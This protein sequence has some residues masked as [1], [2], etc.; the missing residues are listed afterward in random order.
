MTSKMLSPFIHGWKVSNDG[1]AG[2]FLPDYRDDASLSAPVA[3]YTWLHLNALD[4][5]CEAWLVADPDIDAVATKILTAQDSRPRLIAH[6]DQ[7]LINLRGVNLNEG[8]DPTD[9]VGIRFIISA[10]RIVSV[11]RRPLKATTDMVDLLNNQNAPH[12]PGQ[13]IAQFALRL[14]ERMGPFISE[15]D[16]KVTALEE[17]VDKFLTS[18]QR[19]LLSDLRQ[20]VIFIRRYL[21]PQRDALNMLGL[22]T[23]SWLSDADRLHVR[24]AADQTTRITEEL[25]ALR[26]RCGVIRDQMVDYQSEAMNRNMMILSIIAAIFLPLGLISG[27]LG[28]NVGGVPW[29]NDAQGFWYVCA[30]IAATGVGQFIIFKYLKWL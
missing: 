8:G 28:M 17:A 18:A 27:I 9:M 22:Q 1:Q 2:S 4:P 15:L 24:S 12:T 25:D 7:I 5:A 26:E 11:S 14:V 29:V 13:F 6:G 10:N 20:D 3:A 16:D 19:Q 21:T 30:I 23:A